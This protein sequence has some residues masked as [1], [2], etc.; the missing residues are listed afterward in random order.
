MTLF[1][2]LKHYMLY[3]DKEN[4]KDINRTT[5][6]ENYIQMKLYLDEMFKNT[7]CGSGRLGNC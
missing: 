6:D 1:H 7:E 2:M 3:R 5:A 4:I